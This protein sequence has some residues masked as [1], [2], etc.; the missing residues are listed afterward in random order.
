MLLNE[1]MKYRYLLFDADDTL[2]DFGKCEATA[3]EIALSSSLLKFSSELWERYHKINDDLWK[4]LE[5]GFV[6]RD[7]IRTE[8][9]KR[10]F[11]SCGVFDDS[12]L[13]TAK[14]YEKAL[15]E[16]LFEID[17]AWE[18]LG[19]LSE[20]YELYVITNGVTA[21]QENRFSNSRI[22][23]IVRKVYISEQMGTAKP[24]PLFFEKVFADIGDDDREKYLVIGDSL[25]SDIS[26]AENVGIDSIW[27]AKNGSDPCGRH[28]TYTVRDLSE[29][30]PILL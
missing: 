6:T 15:S 22:G 7:V 11:E 30:Y 14:N 2:F 12:Y 5:K 16:Q 19:K 8:R 28:P 17:G 25:T 18:L 27:Y 9:Y 3:L 29:I 26:G 20:K 24:S 1:I 10:L 4:D 21:V 23:K 13:V